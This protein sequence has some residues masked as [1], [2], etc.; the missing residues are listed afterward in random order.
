MKCAEEEHSLWVGS[1]RTEAVLYSMMSLLSSCC[2]F[3]FYN[4]LFLCTCAFLSSHLTHFSCSV[5]GK[6]LYFW[7]APLVIPKDL[8]VCWMVM[9]LNPLCWTFLC[10]TQ[11][12]LSLL[13]LFLSIFVVLLEMDLPG[14]SWFVI[15]KHLKS[16][17]INL[18]VSLQS[19][20]FVVLDVGHQSQAGC[21]WAHNY[22]TITLRQPIS[23]F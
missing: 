3:V 16:N 6:A 23:A 1:Q 14:W 22:K 4:G 19:C 13:P 5:L 11:K 18:I 10:T 12:H 21:Q 7:R 8:Y 20:L 15:P 9:Y 17:P 2:C